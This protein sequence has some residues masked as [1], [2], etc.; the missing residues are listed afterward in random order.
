MDDIWEVLIMGDENNIIA[1]IN[2]ATALFSAKKITEDQF[3]AKMMEI[4]DKNEFGIEISV[5]MK[6]Y[7][8]GHES[9]G[10]GGEAK[11][12]LW[13]WGGQVSNSFA[14]EN[15]NR[16][17]EIADLLCKAMNEGGFK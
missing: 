12:I 2:K 6:D 7:K 16:C 17:K 13:D 14:T 1:K 3:S 15:V 4:E 9:W 8:H 10:W 5:I 11:I